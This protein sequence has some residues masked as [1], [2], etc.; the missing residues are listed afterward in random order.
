STHP[1][2]AGLQSQ[3]VELLLDHGAAIN[4]VADDDSPLMTA[5]AF[6]Y[7]DAA[8]TLAR[9]GARVDGVLPAAALGRLN[10]VRQ[11]V[12]DANPRSPDARVVVPPWF[13]MPRDA[14]SQIALALVWACEFN[15]TEVAE[16]LLGKGVD[17]SAK[18]NNAM[19]TL[20]YAAA[21]GNIALID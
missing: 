3:L 6:G 12:V 1:A 7:R 21:N 18:D 10:L 17:P 20:H 13:D 8:Q 14:R 5:L 9:R 15:R 4:G 2:G 19:T 11:F 16:F